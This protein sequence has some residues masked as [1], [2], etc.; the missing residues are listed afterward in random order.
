MGIK[1]KQEYEIP[2]DVRVAAKT[3]PVTQKNFSVALLKMRYDRMEEEGSD[4]SRED[5]SLA[6]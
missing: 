2:F 3:Y 6:A 5:A 1:T 4:P